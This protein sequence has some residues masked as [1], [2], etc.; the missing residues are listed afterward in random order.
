MAFSSLE[1]VTVDEYLSF[2]IFQ[3]LEHIKGRFSG[4][5]YHKCTLR[6]VTIVSGKIDDVVLFGKSWAIPEN[7]KKPTRTVNA[8]P[9]RK[10]I[11]KVDGDN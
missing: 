1:L 3:M 5:V 11:P 10:P 7:T 4:T 2:A 8:K 9:G 6:A